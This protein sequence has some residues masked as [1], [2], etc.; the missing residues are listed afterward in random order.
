MGESGPDSVMRSPRRLPL[1]LA[2][3]PVVGGDRTGNLERAVRWIGKAAAEGAELILLPE[4]LDLGWSHPS[5]RTDAEP[6][7]GGEPFRALSEAAR[8][9]GLFVCAGLTER[10]ENGRIYNTAVLIDRSGELLGRHRK[11]HELEV[12]RTVYDEGESVAVFETELGRIGIMIC[13]DGFAKDLWIGRALGHLGADLLLSPSAW[14]VSPEHDQV[15]EPYGNLWRRSYVPICEEFGIGIAAVSNVGKLEAGPWAGRHCIGCSL[16]L[17]PGG[18]EIVQGPYGPHAEALLRVEMELPERSPIDAWDEGIGDEEFLRHFEATTLPH[19]EW[20]HRAHL[21]VAFLYAS[22]F[23]F[24]EAL[25]QMR[26]GIQT[27]NQAKGIE[28]TPTSGYHETL[29]QVW[30][31][32][33]HAAMRQEGEWKGTEEFLERNSQLLEKR[34]L[35]YF[36]SR[37]R[38][39]SGEARS[40]FVEPD[41]VPLPPDP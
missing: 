41:L 30:F 34:S 35:L 5:A 29:T 11:V 23:P 13:A 9:N 4:T 36:Y 25:E 2:Q 19:S 16:A 40:A 1:A 27:Y 28:T 38:I 24:G 17:G 20:N 33:V 7:P 37:D 21:K 8:R 14:A 31:R 18:E 3:M 26:R 10:G 39:L 6:I 22:R 12:G 32:L 15:T